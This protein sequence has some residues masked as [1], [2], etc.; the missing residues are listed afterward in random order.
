MPTPSF[1]IGQ[2]VNPS[3]FRETLLEFHEQL[4]TSQLATVRKLRSHSGAPDADSA[5]LTRGKP[6]RKGRSHIDLAFDILTAAD[7]PLHASEI[8]AKVSA[9]FGVHID[10]ESLVSALSKRVAR[11]DRFTRTGRNTFALL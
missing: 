3:A 9:A 11:K 6:K 4:L 1:P 2:E 7:V 5:P 8:I 10:S